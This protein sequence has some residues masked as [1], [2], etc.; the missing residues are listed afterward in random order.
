M[1]THAY[2]P[3]IS[4][5]ARFAGKINWSDRW[6]FHR[7]LQDAGPSLALSDATRPGD[8]PGISRVKIDDFHHRNL[9]IIL[10]PKSVGQCR[11][12]MKTQMLFSHGNIRCYLW[13][14]RHTH[15]INWLATGL[16]T[17]GPG[18]SR[19]FQTLLWKNFILGWKLFFNKCNRCVFPLP[20][21]RFP[22]A[23]ACMFFY[24]NNFPLCIVLVG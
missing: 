1:L 11:K 6:I 15:C 17:R 12:H 7:H 2:P 16:P 18:L 24:M 5:R 14:I 8:A 19:D 13:H 10:W 4:S 20:V 23:N 21:F 9:C 22:E 3:A